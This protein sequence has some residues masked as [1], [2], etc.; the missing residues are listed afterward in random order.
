MKSINFFLLIALFA[1]NL[2]LTSCSQQ[3]TEVN[4][5]HEGMHEDHDMGMESDDNMNGNM[6]EPAENK[7]MTSNT[8][9]DEQTQQVITH[10]L[11]LKN[12]L[13]KTDA[14]AASTA[15]KELVTVLE[16]EDALIQKLKEDSKLI[17]EATES[18][19][20]RTHFSA[21]SDN[22]YELV[23]KS[24]SNETVLYRQHCPMAFDNKGANWLSAEE[25]IKNPYFGDK[26]LSCGKVTETIAAKTE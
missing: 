5:N 22:L 4:E 25:E 21:L 9:S 12:A 26:M 14:T 18:E 1:V 17:T 20:Q 10:Y 2:G 3:K 23:S 8:L 6:A 13:V 16:G 11:S 7:A 19:V 15:A 24:S